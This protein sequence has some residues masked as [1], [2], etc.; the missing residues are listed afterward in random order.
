[1]LA[2]NGTSS[3]GKR[4]V[5][6]WTFYEMTAPNRLPNGAWR[7]LGWDMRSGSSNRPLNMSPRAFGHGGFTGTAFWFDPATKLF[8]LVLSNRVYPDGKGEVNVLAGEVGEIAVHSITDLADD[9]DEYTRIVR[10]EKESLE[11]IGGADKVKSGLDVVA[12]LSTLSLPL[13]SQ[14][15]KVK[16]F[17]LI[18]NHTAV[19]LG[20]KSIVQVFKEIPDVKL[21]AIFSPEHG[22][23][24]QF[25]QKNIRDSTDADSG[26]P[27]Y[28]LYDGNVRRPTAA[29]MDNVD[30]FVFDIQDVGTRFYTYISTM[31]Y[32]MEAAAMSSAA[33]EPKEFIVLDRPNPIRGDI[34]EGVML[35]AGKEL[36]VGCSRLPIRHGL[37]AG[38]LALLFNAQRRLRLNV[39]VIPCLGWERDMDY[40]VT[41]LR[42]IAPSP[43]MRS[44]DA[45]FLYPGIGLLEFTNISVGRGTDKPFEQIGATWID[46]ERLV[47]A[48]KK[49]ADAAQVE[50]VSFAACKF[51]PESSVYAGEECNGVSFKIENRK[52]LRSVRLGIVLATTLH[53][54]YPKQW[55]TK[56]LNTLLLDEKTQRLI[57]DNATATEIEAAWQKDLERFMKIREQV[58][59][60]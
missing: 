14:D 40:D 44:V 21:T 46:A 57:L 56:N 33:S 51:K 11:K 18:T 43:N 19:T 30:V 12:S 29:M 55:E 10:R 20:G 54:L 6:E 2:G 50:G 32:V 49:K 38:E 7:G 13:S 42:W 53:E 60:Y 9:A 25:D 16:R 31:L 5:H 28:S 52:A 59:I 1:M 47:E 27:V 37:T 8:V 24:G 23:T 3:G 58:L 41:T 15:L 36:F 26:I 34:V 35:Q 22:F 17:G 4:I 39:S 48:L 45:A